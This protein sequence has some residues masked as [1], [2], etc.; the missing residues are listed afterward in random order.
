MRRASPSRRTRF[1]GKQVQ[2]KTIEP[3]NQKMG[4]HQP[5]GMSNSVGSGLLTGLRVTAIVP[6]PKPTIQIV[7]KMN[8]EK[9][10]SLADRVRMVTFEYVWLT[11]ALSGDRRAISL[12]IHREDALARRPL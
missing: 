7:G 8:F 5:T 9:K 4:K 10:V 12:S 11:L 3:A 1:S 6:R 2:V